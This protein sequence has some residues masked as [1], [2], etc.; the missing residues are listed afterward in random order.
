MLGSKSVPRQGQQIIGP[1]A[2][3]R[4]S[5]IFVYFPQFVLA[6]SI[7][8]FGKDEALLTFIPSWRD[9]GKGNYTHVFVVRSDSLTAYTVPVSLDEI[10]VAVAELRAGLDLGNIERLSNL[11][12]FDTTLAFELYEKLFKPAEKMLAEVRTLLRVR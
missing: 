6:I 1:S 5:Q 4:P 10:K 7:P 3:T 8:L 2:S 12:S 11:F 9:N